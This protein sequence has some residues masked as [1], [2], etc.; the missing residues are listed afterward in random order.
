MQWSGLIGI[1]IATLLFACC[2]SVLAVMLRWRTYLQAVAAIEGRKY[3]HINGYQYLCRTSAW[4]SNLLLPTTLLIGITGSLFASF[5]LFPD[6]ILPKPLSTIGVLF[7]IFIAPNLV[8][9]GLLY[10]LLGIILVDVPALAT[11]NGSEIE[12]KQA[13]ILGLKSCI[14][15]PLYNERRFKIGPS[16]SLLMLILLEALGLL[17]CFRLPYLLWLIP[18]LAA[19]ANIFYYTIGS[20]HIIAWT[21]RTIP[22]E[23]SPW[24]SLV[25]HIDEWIRLAGVKRQ[26]IRIQTM[27]RIGS[28]NGAISDLFHPV[29]LLNNTVLAHS[30]WRQQEALL[31]WMIRLVHKRFPTTYIWLTSSLSVISWTFLAAGA[32]LLITFSPHHSQWP[33]LISPLV[34]I[35]LTYAITLLITRKLTQHAAFEADR[36]AA[37]LTS[38]PLALMVALHTQHSLNTSRSHLPPA[39]RKRIAALY[40]LTLQSNASHYWINEPVPSLLPFSFEEKLLT[41]PLHQAEL[42]TFPTAEPINII[43][44]HD[45]KTKKPNTDEAQPQE[46]LLDDECAPE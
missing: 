35:I 8:V 43:S 3:I 32:A 31:A 46:E 18:L 1:G 6:I 24:A 20:R 28:S 40:Q 27:I 11:F 29:L 13:L 17:H 15:G 23:Q 42:T 10:D 5:Y 19:C 41:T 21:T 2:I 44:L 30:D 36:F 34:A 33:G 38:D 9:P 7:C 12:P 45:Y 4:I 39:T 26:D 25:L 14:I 22:I 16:P 37:E